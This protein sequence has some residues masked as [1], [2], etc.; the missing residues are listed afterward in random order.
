MGGEEATGGE[1]VCREAGEG[2]GAWRRSG[3]VCVGQGGNAG[4]KVRLRTKLL[5]LS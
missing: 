1:G 3:R 5:S 2:R 4:Q